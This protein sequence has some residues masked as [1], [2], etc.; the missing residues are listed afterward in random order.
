MSAG[1]YAEAEQQHAAPAE[2]I[3]EFTNW[4]QQGRHGEGVGVDDP[5]NFAR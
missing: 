3:A 1:E 4:Q 5:E 2:A